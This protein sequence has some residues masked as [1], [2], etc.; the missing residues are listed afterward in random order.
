MLTQSAHR[1]F[2]MKRTQLIALLAAVAALAGAAAPGAFAAAPDPTRAALVTDMA[3]LDRLYIAALALSNQG[4]PEAAARVMPALRDRA[5]QFNAR[6]SSDF[7]Q[8]L[9]WTTGLAEV[10]S[11][12][13][14]AEAGLS[15]G[16]LAEVHET[17]EGIRAVFMRLRE[18]RKIEYYVDYLNAYHTV[19]EEASAVAVGKTAQGFSAA[20]IRAAAGFIPLLRR[21]WAAALS[22]EFDPGLYLFTDA[23]TTELRKAM[24]G[25]LASIDALDAAVKGGSGDKVLAAVNALK[26]AFTRSFLVFGDL[27][28]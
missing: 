22:A 2:S 27:G 1:R 19:M 6:H 11:L 20:D 16:S 28:K 25:T 15:G 8:D 4:K 10:T 23:R 18:E 26:P 14:A 7:G 5:A 12:I 17:L 21:S 9:G 24:Q 13:D 3:S